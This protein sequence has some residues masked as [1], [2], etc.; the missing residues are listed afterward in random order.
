[1]LRSL[2]GD[3]A[4]RIRLLGKFVEKNYEKIDRLMQLRGDYSSRVSI[5]N[6]NIRSERATLSTGDQVDLTDEWLSRRLDA[7]LFSLQVCGFKA[8]HSILCE[9]WFIL[10]YISQLTLSL[11]GLLPRTTVREHTSSNS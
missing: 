3:S 8:P 2:P 6:Q 7:G 11:L 1:M 4:A 9:S 5:V 10:I